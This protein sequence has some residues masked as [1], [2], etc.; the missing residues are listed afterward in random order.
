MPGHAGGIAAILLAAGGGS[1]LGG[2]K[3]LLPWRGLPLIAHLL[4]TLG[5]THGLD[6]LTIVLGHRADAVREALTDS[7]AGFP[8]PVEFT[9]NRNWRKG[10]GASLAV[11][12]KHALAAPGGGAVNSA[13]FLLG[14]QPLVTADT[15]NAL[16]RAHAEALARTPGHP[17][18]VP[19]YRGQ[20]GN[21]VILSQRLFPRLMTLS[22][23]AGARHILRELDAELLRVAVDDPGVAHDVDTP[24]AYAALLAR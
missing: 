6:S 23:D 11:G 3:L 2:G 13:L 1:R 22:G 15:L 9:R 21:P 4:R 5:Q 7:L 18:T 8:V 19:V 20:R 17:A 10:L 24:E 14:D 16:I 12:L